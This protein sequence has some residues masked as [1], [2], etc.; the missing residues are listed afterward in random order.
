[1]SVMQF[2]RETRGPVTIDPGWVDINMAPVHRALSEAVVAYLSRRLIDGADDLRFRP[3]ATLAHAHP[4]DPIGARPPT[5]II[6]SLP[7]ADPDF[8]L[9][10]ATDIEYLVEDALEMHCDPVEGLTVD[11][12]ARLALSEIADALARQA[13]RIRTALEVPIAIV[14]SAAAPG[15]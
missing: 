7:V 9:E 6:V 12:A 2:V 4:R 8:P 15:R 11:P 14:P 10:L 3:Y 1:M 5:A 13:Q